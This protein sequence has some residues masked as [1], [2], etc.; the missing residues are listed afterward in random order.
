MSVQPNILV[1]KATRARHTRTLSNGNKQYACYETS[2]P[3]H[4]KPEGKQ[5]DKKIILRIDQHVNP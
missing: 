1:R 3:S 2:V 5:L 4:K